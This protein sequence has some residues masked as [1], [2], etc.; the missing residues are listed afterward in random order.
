AGCSEASIFQALL[1]A[2]LV[3]RQPHQW[4][5]YRPAVSL[6]EQGMRFCFDFLA[7]LKLPAVSPR[8]RNIHIPPAPTAALNVPERERPSRP[9]GAMV[10]HR[11][12]I[13]CNAA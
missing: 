8:E 5:W 4:R 13:L 9:T 1:G 12:Y 7:F 2:R 6:S 10:S 11:L 3:S